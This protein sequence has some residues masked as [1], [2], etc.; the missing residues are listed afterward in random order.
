M[1]GQKLYDP[2]AKYAKKWGP[3]IMAHEDKEVVHLNA[4]DRQV[5]TE[6]D[7]EQNFEVCKEMIYGCMELSLA[8]P[9][10]PDGKMAEIPK[11]CD[12]EACLS[13]M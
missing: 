5:I 2:L 4:R 10:R 1:I 7:L 6:S 8:N 12:F 9:P 3:T 11:L 13:P